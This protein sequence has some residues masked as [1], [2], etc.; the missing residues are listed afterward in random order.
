MSDNKIQ[1]TTNSNKRPEWLDS[2]D[3]QLLGDIDMTL[4][5]M[6]DDKDGFAIGDLE[7]GLSDCGS[8][9]SFD[10]IS[11]PYDNATLK[12]KDLNEFYE[13]LGEMVEHINRN[14]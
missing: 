1:I 3:K 6:S 13:K 2:D 9:I 8:M 14:K 11:D 12:T 7:V 5:A 10:G 4:S